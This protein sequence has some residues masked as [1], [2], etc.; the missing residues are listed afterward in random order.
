MRTVPALALAVCAL[1]L[2]Y[3]SAA[4]QEEH[5]VG[6]TAGYP[7]A[8]GLVWH[9]SDRLALRPE[10]SIARTTTNTI[11]SAYDGGES[12]L[13]SWSVGVS[14]SGL[15]YLASWG[16]LRTYLSPRFAYTWNRATSKS[17]GWNPGGSTTKSPSYALSGS[18]GAEYALARRLSV[19]FEAGLG[20]SDQHQN[21]SFIETSTRSWS[22]RTGVG[23]VFYF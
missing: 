1:V 6:L 3:G 23:A 7:A 8:V 2:G 20:Y 15:I 10:V 18:V 5:R 21:S 16:D 22:T 14:L 13:N 4:A 12:T 17:E 19:Y 11:I 9:V